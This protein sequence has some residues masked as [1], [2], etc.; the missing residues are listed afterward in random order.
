MESRRGTGPQTTH[1]SGLRNSSE[2]CLH[3]GSGDSATDGMAMEGVV[4][5]RD[6]PDELGGNTAV[7]GTQS[8]ERDANREREVAVRIHGSEPLMLRLPIRRRRDGDRGVTSSAMEATEELVKEYASSSRT[9]RSRGSQWKEWIDFCKEDR[10]NTFPV[11]EGHMVAFIG[12]I[13]LAR[14]RG[15][16][17]LSSYSVP[18][19]LS[20]VRKM[21]LTLTGTFIPSFPHWKIVLRAYRK[22]EEGNYLQPTVR[23]GLSA[24][25]LQR[26][27]ELGMS[28][29]E[30]ETVRECAAYVFTYYFNGIPES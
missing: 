21:N 7:S 30:N 9:M 12:W 25:V 18:K 1:R 28:S 4:S 2:V 29:A 14:E 16:R 20:A 10:S 22:W 11:K 27:W 23:C 3:L 8:V 17:C 13:Q 6:T 19:Y 5:N 26:V 15:D 24:D